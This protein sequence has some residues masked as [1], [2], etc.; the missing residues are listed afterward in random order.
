[1]AER[2]ALVKDVEKVL[3]AKW[4]NCGLRLLPFGSTQTGLL[5]ATSDVDLTII[6]PMRPYGVGTVSTITG[7]CLILGKLLMVHASPSPKTNSDS[8]QRMPSLL[9][10]Q[11]PSLSQ[12]TG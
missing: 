2:E 12:D 8:H 6:D 10:C 11:T 7:V 1:M 9:T 3:E 4:P 5:E